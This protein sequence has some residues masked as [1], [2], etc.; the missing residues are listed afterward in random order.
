MKKLY[1]FAIAALLAAPLLAQKPAIAPGYDLWKTVGDGATFMSFVDSP[2]P[3]GFFYEGS[4][5]FTGKIEFNGVPL[6]TQPLDALGG[7]DTIVERL[8]TSVFNDEGVAVSRMRI[9]ALSLVAA[10]PIEVDGSLWDVTAS[11][12]EKQPVTEITYYQQGADSG[13]YHADLVVNV[14]LTFTHRTVKK[15]AYTLDRTVHFSD[16]H[17]TPFRLVDSGD[18][19]KGRLNVTVDTNG[20]GVA[21]TALTPIQRLIPALAGR[22]IFNPLYTPEQLE[23]FHTN[24]THAHITIAPF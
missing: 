18:R 12:A 2:I 5:A 21:E 17:E 3:A 9:K 8:D 20:D 22:T 6:A 7:A 16:Y 10:D 4:E 23:G 14:R 24:P 13:V 11:L 19:M 15:L 1:A